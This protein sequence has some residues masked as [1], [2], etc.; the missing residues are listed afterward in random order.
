MSETHRFPTRIYW[1]DN[2]A[3]GIV[4]YANYLRFLERGH[5][6]LVRGAGI[7]QAA[8]LDSEGVMFPVRRC[9]INYLQPAHLDNQ[10]EAHTRIQNIGGAS[11]EMGLDIH[12][13]DEHI[14]RAKGRLACVGRSGRPQRLAAH[15][16]AALNE[17]AIAS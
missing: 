13:G 1:E 2:D 9:E 11:M 15:I 10:I 12:R 8:L 14:V 17:I 7:D 4:Y 6:D 3:A 16:R 5:S